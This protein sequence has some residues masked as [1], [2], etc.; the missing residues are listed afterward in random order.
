MTAKLVA[1]QAHAKQVDGDAIDFQRPARQAF[2]LKAKFLIKP[3]RGEIVVTHLKVDAFKALGESESERLCHQRGAKPP[4]AP[5]L[6]DGHREAA[7]VFPRFRCEPLD[8][9]TPHHLR[10]DMG[11]D[12]NAACSDRSAYGVAKT[13]DWRRR[14]G[15]KK[16]A[17]GHNLRQQAVKPVDLIGAKPFDAPIHDGNSALRKS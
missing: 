12:E 17:F 2:N 16:N 9:A 4:P 5:R 1:Q 13:I 15:R 10:A 7:G 14:E 8:F 6:G 3:A 11:A